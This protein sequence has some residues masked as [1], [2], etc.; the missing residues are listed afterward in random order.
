MF[1]S[2]LLAIVGMGPGIARNEEKL[3]IYQKSLRD[4]GVSIDCFVADAGEPESLERVLGQ[5]ATPDILVYNAA[6]LRRQNVLETSFADLTKDFQTNVVGALVAV[7]AV[8]N[9]MQKGQKSGTIILT[10]GGFAL[11]PDPNFAS[12]AIGKAGIRNLTQSLA[13][14]LKSEGI[15]IGT[16][17]ICGMV[18][19]LDPK[20]NPTAI[21]EEYWQFYA[22][23]I[24]GFEV[25]Y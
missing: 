17:T 8:R 14:A 6:V 22:T 7:R 21:A 3:Q 18:N 9:A 15:K 1:M 16:I 4:E 13:I 12:L 11:Y 19:E 20:Y 25:V 10:G 5:L 24:E 23:P 2:K